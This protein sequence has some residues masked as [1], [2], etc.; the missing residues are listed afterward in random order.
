MYAK[1][2]AQIL[3]SSIAE[4]PEV[5]F[6]FMDLLILA[7]ADGVVDMTPEAIARRT[8][9]DLVTVCNALKHLEMPD[10]KSRTAD[11]GGARIKRLDEHRDWGWMIVNYDKFRRLATDMQRREH[12]RLRVKRFREQNGAC[13]AD[14]TP[15]NA[16][17]QNVTPPYAYTYASSSTSSSG[18]EGVG[19]NPKRKNGIPS[20]AEEVVAYG[21]SINPPIDERTCR[22]FF[23]HYEGQARTDPNGDIFWIT[24]GDAV[25]TNWKAKLPSFT[26]NQKANANHRTSP[27]KG[28]DRNKGTLNEGKAALYRNVGK[29]SAVPAAKSIPTPNNGA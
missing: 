16:L 25:V 8:N 17:S 19:E 7:D 22:D 11:C 28:F 1:I 15:G 14:V 12:T 21:K 13:N 23:A 4:Y 29:P 5:R 24:S 10:P 18:K 3:D 6:T 20:S 26:L 27:A 9:R 2:F